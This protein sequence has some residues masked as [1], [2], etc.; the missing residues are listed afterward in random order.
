[1]S[2][3]FPVLR[4]LAKLRRRARRLARQ[5]AML[6]S[7]IVGCMWWILSTLALTGAAWV[8]SLIVL[9]LSS[10]TAAAAWLVSGE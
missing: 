8:V 4:L 6:T 7:A 3:P 2:L 1:M 5:V 10:I 9:V